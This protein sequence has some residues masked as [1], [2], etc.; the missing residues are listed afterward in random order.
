MSPAV[1]ALSAI[2]VVG[3]F[4]ISH[5]VDTGD[6]RRFGEPVMFALAFAGIAKAHALWIASG[7]AR[8]VFLTV[9]GENGAPVP[10][11]EITVEI[12][13]VIANWR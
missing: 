5:Y 13:M 1:A 6:P 9:A 11:A 10:N 8:G 7:P 3:E 2:G 4:A 12:A